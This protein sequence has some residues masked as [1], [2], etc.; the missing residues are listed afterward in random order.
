MNGAVDNVEL[1]N[2]ACA[3]RRPAN[4]KSVLG[5]V[6]DN[7]GNRM[8]NRVNKDINLQKTCQKHVGKMFNIGY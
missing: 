1:E 2:H 3:K 8:R 4:K 6:G 5:T 7:F